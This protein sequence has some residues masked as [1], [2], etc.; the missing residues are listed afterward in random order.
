MFESVGP[1]VVLAASSDE[2]HPPENITDGSVLPLNY[3]NLVNLSLVYMSNNDKLLVPF[4][5]KHQNVL[6]IHRDVSSRVR[7]SLCR[8]NEVFWSDSGQLQW[9][10]NSGSLN[11]SSL[12]R[13]IVQML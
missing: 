9:Y 12:C 2:N 6:D 7:P 4:T 3:D 11:D 1:H 10:I 5:Q 8:T 13:E